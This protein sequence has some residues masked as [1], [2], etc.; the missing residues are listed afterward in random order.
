[1]KKIIFAVLVALLA[2]IPLTAEAGT[3]SVSVVGY[4]AIDIP[5]PASTFDF[6]VHARGNG[7]S[8]EGVVW[9]SH[10]DDTRIAWAVARVDCVRR[11]GRVV[12]ITGV[13]GDAQDFA[14]AEPGDAISLS[15]RDGGPDQIG[16]VS[17]DEVTRCHGLVPERA[18][19]RGDFVISRR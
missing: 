7:R 1:M 10:H 12:I 4:A 11:I 8:G 2:I 5:E 16:F 18:I 15:V 6:R 3:R 17:G 19:D 9:L 14:A 13:V